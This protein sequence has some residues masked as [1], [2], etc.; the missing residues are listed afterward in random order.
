MNYFL[1][2][3]LLTIFVILAWFTFLQFN[4]PDAIIWIGIYGLSALI[5]LL[6]LFNRFYK[7]LF[8]LAITCC[9]LAALVEAKGAYTYFLHRHEEALMQSMNPAKPFIEEAREFLGSLIG[10]VLVVSSRF[11]I[12]RGQSQNGKNNQ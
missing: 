8:W 3:F 12:K 11:M 5:P 2:F 1:K 7:P 4:D 6:G 10:I 9:V